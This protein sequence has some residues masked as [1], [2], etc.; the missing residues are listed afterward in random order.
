MIAILC[1]IAWEANAQPFMGNEPTWHSPSI[2]GES[3]ARE[4]G[5][6]TLPNERRVRVL[7]RNGIDPN[8]SAFVNEAG[9]R[10]ISIDSGVNILIYNFGDFATVEISTDRLVIWTTD[11]SLSSMQSDTVQEADVPLEFY[12]EGN[13]VFR[14]GDRVIH[15]ERMYYD[16]RSESGVILDSEM[17]T[18]MIG[19]NGLVRLKSEVLQRINAQQYVGTN[20]GMTTSRMGQPRYWLQSNQFTFDSIPQRAVDPTTGRPTTKQGGI[21]TSRGNSVFLGSLPIFYWPSI[22]TSLDKPS[23][24]L[25]A[26]SIN[27][28]RVFGTQVLTGWDL[29]QLLGIRNPLQESEWNLSL[30]YLS[31]RGFGVGTDFEYRIEN[32]LNRPGVAAGFLD[33]WGI[34]DGGLDVLGRKRRNLQPEEDFRG[35]LYGRHRHRF[36][37]GYQFSAEVGLISDRNFLES[38][39]EREWD[40]EKD[41]TTGVE[42][43]RLDENRSWSVTADLQ[44]NDFFTQ[45][46]W[47]PRADHYWI[48]QSILGDWLNWNEH[49]SIGYANLN[50]ATQPLDPEDAKFFDPLA[51]ET[52]ASGLRAATRQEISMPMEMGPFKIVPYGL[53]EAAYFPEDLNGND[54]ERLFGQTGI[55]ASL[56]M[57]SVNHDAHSDLFN[58]NGIAHKHV[59]ET[60]FLYAD[61]NQ[62]S[63]QLPLYDKLDDDSIEL[64]R[65]MFFFETF[66]GTKGIGAN[67]PSR[68]DERSYALRSNLQGWTT[69]PTTEIAD[70]LMA[71]RLASEHRWQTKRGLPGR[72]HIVDLV[73][74][75][76]QG[77]IYPRAD[78]D[79]F[80]Q[81]L[82]LI[83]YDFEWHPGDRFTVQSDGQFDLFN[84]GLRTVYL[85]AVVTR[86]SRGRYSAGVR[87]IE[88]PISSQIFFGSTSYRLSEKWIVRYG[89]SYDF[90]KTGN[91]GQNGQIIRVGE[92][93]LIAMGFNYD[94]SRDNFGLKFA[95]E[96]RFFGGKLSRIPGISIHPTGAAGLE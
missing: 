96:P 41:Q 82:G 74:L 87:S 16:V 95:I 84:E 50:T 86:P 38:Y 11:D 67:V 78:R 24:Y 79:N 4:L 72:Q 31:E 1:S 27:N 88:G 61:A 10:V 44:V 51:W 40:H 85:G 80:G 26:L 55:R 45:T 47:L 2:L 22:R 18:P 91:L 68:F 69:S 35:R 81:E 58:I 71:F 56:P 39:Y 23:Y 19:Y 36:A 28:D 60:E 62:D 7:P 94:S 43:K 57:W 37:G 12:M 77:F 25:N 65:R 3:G 73:K 30:D 14:E 32:F 29:Y 13:I 21:I 20:S 9:E 75:D 17:L 83:S 54:V 53:G 5:G 64:F 15:A 66:G 93:F 92:T 52:N 46:E 33:A 59:L 49:S 6:A 89:S 63:D 8:Y 70:D 42:F 90:G 76:L 48:G 34:N